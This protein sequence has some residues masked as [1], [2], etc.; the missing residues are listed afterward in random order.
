M[1]SQQNQSSIMAQLRPSNRS[2]PKNRCQLIF[3]ETF[4]SSY[5]H[6]PGIPNI[7]WSNEG[8]L[9]TTVRSLTTTVSDTVSE[10][11]TVN[12]TDSLFS[13]E[14][15]GVGRKSDVRVAHPQQVATRP[16]ADQLVVASQLRGTSRC[17]I[18]EKVRLVRG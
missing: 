15:K 1:R 2:V 3:Y 4:D 13:R 6:D 7:F 10:N 17:G 12:L 9:D 14:G 16:L 18:E 5:F 11:Q 8:Q